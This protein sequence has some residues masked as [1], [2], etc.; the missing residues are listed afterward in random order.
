MF[1]YVNISIYT[2]LSIKNLL[3]SLSES[4][5]FID[6]YI[7]QLLWSIFVMLYFFKMSGIFLY[8]FRQR[9]TTF[10]I[11]F[12]CVNHKDKE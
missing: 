7:V 2:N 1:L 5:V 6:M 10:L 12:C 8:V 11:L 3:F 4:E 9:N